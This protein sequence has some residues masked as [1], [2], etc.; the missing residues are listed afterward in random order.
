STLADGK[1]AVAA[2]AW[3]LQPANWWQ[4]I[5]A[6]TASV[7]NN[8]L[9]SA[10]SIVAIA[11]W[12]IGR[13]RIRKLAGLVV[14]SSATDSTNGITTSSEEQPGLRRTIVALLATLL[15]ASCWPVAL[16]SFASAIGSYTAADHSA[17]F[18]IAL[19]SALSICAGILL[20]LSVVREICRRHGL[21]E[22][23]FAWPADGLAQLRR[24]TGILIV[25]GLPLVLGIGILEAHGH[26]AWRNSLGRLLLVLCQLVLVRFAIVTL[27]HPHGSLYRLMALDRG[28]WMPKL[29]SSILI[30]SVAIPLALSGLAIAGYYFTA[31]QLACRLEATIWWILGLVVAHAITSRWLLQLAARVAVLHPQRAMPVQTSEDDALLFEEDSQPDVVASQH[32]AENFRLLHSVTL[33]ALA[34]AMWLVWAD[35]LPALR[36]L[37]QVT[38]WTNQID[39]TH[40]DPVSL[41]D[42]L[43]ATAIA[44]ITILAAADLPP[45]LERVLL[46]RLPLDAGLR[47]ALNAVVRYVVAI[48]GLA[49][50]GGA[51]G[52]GWPKMQWL[53]A[54]VSFGLGFGLQE[55]FANF[56]SGLIIFWERPVRIGD[57]VTVDD[58]TGVVSRI[59]M[60]ATTILDPDR[61]ELIVPNKEFITSHVVNWTLS[62]SVVRLVLPVNWPV[63]TDPQLVQ[64]MLMRIANENAA[65]LKHP[66]AKV[67]LIS[68]GDKALSFEL[69]VFV[70]DVDSL[71]TT[72]HQLNMAIDR[73]LRTAAVGNITDKAAVIK[74]LKAA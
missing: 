26:D 7:Q 72:R 58:M 68:L 10:F 13:K 42:L 53:M 31:L 14:I 62:D 41:A 69:R 39:A 74:E 51:I 70:A 50:A 63:A 47:Y 22:N 46:H 52:I 28:G 45:L 19:A 59:Q 48:F 66:S 17:D 27:R 55:I 16:W 65:V 36:L 67:A 21:G 34:I 1:K 73:A 56:V 43:E 64:R 35:V 71:M 15:V 18:A 37:D 54:A 49:F 38:L 11:A 3:M 30:V 24:Q 20:P 12:G 9:F 6:L 5:V 4:A 29:S 57:T 32:A 44:A 2:G 25:A 61:K 8:F 40:S 60:R 33:F 23:Y